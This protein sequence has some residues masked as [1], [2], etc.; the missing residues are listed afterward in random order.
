VCV[1]VVEEWWWK[2]V[3]WWEEGKAFLED[4]RLNE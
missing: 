2:R 1:E 3:W 4:N